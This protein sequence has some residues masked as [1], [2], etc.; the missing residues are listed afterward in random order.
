MGN[1]LRRDIDR[2]GKKANAGVAGAIAQGSIPQ[3]TRPGATGIGIGSGYYGGQSAIAIGASAMTDSGNWIVKGNVS[4]STGG[5]FGV[6]AGALY[7]W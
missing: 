7:Q 6:G 1:S 3:V 4:A 5:R 2:V